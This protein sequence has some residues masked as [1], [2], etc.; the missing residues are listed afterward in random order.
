MG[1]IAE[2]LVNNKGKLASNW[3]E[4][5]DGGYQVVTAILKTCPEFT[6]KYDHWYWIDPNYYHV[7]VL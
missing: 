2:I 7:K 5:E 6:V 3:H 1:D 4:H